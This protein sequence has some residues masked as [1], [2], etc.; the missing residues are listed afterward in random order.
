[1]NLT[2]LLIAAYL[3][4]PLLLFVI[5]RS[6]SFGKGSIGTMLKLFF[7]GVASA[8]P[9]FLMEAA[10][11]LVLRIVLGLFPADAFGGHMP[12]LA[13]ILRAFIAVALIEEGW[14][15]FVL[16]ASTWKQMIMENITDGI[17]ASALVGV[18]F[19]AVIYGAWLAAWYVVPADMGVLREAMP[20]YLGA[21]MVTSFLFGL[22]NILAHFGYSGLMGAFYGIAKN[23]EQKDHGRRAGFLL[24]VSFMLAFLMHGFCASLSGYGAGA[25]KMIWVLIGLALEVILALLMASMLSRAY[26]AGSVD[27][28]NSYSSSEHPPVDFSDSEEF[29]SF[30]ESAAEE[31]GDRDQEPEQDMDW[32]D[33]QDMYRDMELDTDPD[34]DRISYNEEDGGQFPRR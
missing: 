26:D 33:E 28:Y 8:V 30:A 10:L 21:G 11:L 6:G 31:D 4:L 23:S 32:Q 2:I 29:A 3:P 20:E 14:K 1:M 34:P 5:L 18:G 27:T 19:S 25:D 13:A 17:A 16:R 7:L 15:A 12:V 24:F 9:A 22:L